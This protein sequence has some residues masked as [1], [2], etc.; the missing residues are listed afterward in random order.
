MFQARY[1]DPYETTPLVVDG[2]LYTMQGDDVV[3]LDATTGRLFWISKYTPVPEA[4]L[5]CGRISRGLAILGDTLYMAAVDAH[6]I[7]IDAKTGHPLWDTTVAQTTSGYT[8]TVAP[9][10]VERTR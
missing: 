9:S 6:L 10:G 1:L 8:M 3:A 4:R 5:C 2:V 7:A